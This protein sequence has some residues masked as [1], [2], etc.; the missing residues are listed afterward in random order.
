MQLIDENGPMKVYLTSKSYLSIAHTTGTI[1]SSKLGTKMNLLSGDQSIFLSSLL[2][3]K[4][5]LLMWSGEKDKETFLNCS[6]VLTFQIIK[7]LSPTKD[8]KYLS[9]GSHTSP[10]T[11]IPTLIWNGGLSESKVLIIIFVDKLEDASLFES[12][13]HVKAVISSS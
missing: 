12:G 10:N 1:L 9:M 3:E 8:A 2:Q 4:L 11:F 7:L 13:L 5:I 6:Q